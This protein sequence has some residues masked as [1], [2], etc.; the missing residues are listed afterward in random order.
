MPSGSTVPLRLVPSESGAPAGYG[1]PR[2]IGCCRIRPQGA[3]PWVDI[4]RNRAFGL[5]ATDRPRRHGQHA[6]IALGSSRSRRKRGTLYEEQPMTTARKHTNA[7]SGTDTPHDS[8]RP[9]SSHCLPP[10]T[11]AVRRPLALPNKLGP[12]DWAYFWQVN[13]DREFVSTFVS[14]YDHGCHIFSRPATRQYPHLLSSRW[15][16]ATCA[17]IQRRGASWG[18]SVGIRDLYARA[19]GCRQ[20]AQTTA[21]TT[22]TR[23]ES[24]AATHTNTRSQA[25][26]L[27]TPF[28]SPRDSRLGSP[29]PNGSSSSL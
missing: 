23:H 25:R 3:S 4:A 19:G 29:P 22:R 13:T 6:A 20:S 26:L 11:A 17:E 1:L 15:S 5:L 8:P 27:Q 21:T 28:N 14:N 7:P 18:S 2:T 12:V 10:R 24:R 16:R 9:V